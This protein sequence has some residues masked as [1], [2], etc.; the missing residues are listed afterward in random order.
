MVSFLLNLLAQGLDFFKDDN[1]GR[2]NFRFPNLRTVNQVFWWDNLESY[3]K[4]RSD[5][6]KLNLC[7][8]SN[9]LVPELSEDNA[10]PTDNLRQFFW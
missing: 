6:Y 9:I 3:T 2:I 4:D 7:R 5:G 8:R 10:L 1:N